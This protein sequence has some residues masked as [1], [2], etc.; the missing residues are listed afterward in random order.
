M[1]FYRIKQNTIDLIP[2]MKSDLVF[3]LYVSMHH[4]VHPFMPLLWLPESMSYELLTCRQHIIYQ[5]FFQSYLIIST[6]D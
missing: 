2:E 6:K 3:V 1:T 5:L 4:R